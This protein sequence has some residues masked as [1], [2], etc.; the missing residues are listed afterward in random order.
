MNRILTGIGILLFGVGLITAIISGIG[1]VYSRPT[2]T[3][4]VPSYL[5]DAG[6][7]IVFVVVGG[8]MVFFGIKKF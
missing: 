7:A 2:P 8:L 3:A 5:E 1:L 4:N 6:V